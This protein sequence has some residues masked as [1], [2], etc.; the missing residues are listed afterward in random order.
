MKTVTLDILNDEA[1][2][3]LKNLE[4]LKLIR[5]HKGKTS[6]QQTKEQVSLSDFSFSKS[7]EILKDYQ[8]SLSDTVADD[9][10]I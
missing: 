7:R 3:L 2:K 5:F 6:S 9:R 8:G 10:R 4:G 1:I